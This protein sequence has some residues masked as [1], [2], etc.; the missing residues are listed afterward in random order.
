MKLTPAVRLWMLWTP[1]L[2]SSVGMWPAAAGPCTFQAGLRTRTSPRPK[3]ARR[4][5]MLA[6]SPRF[7]VPVSRLFWPGLL[8]CLAAVTAWAQDSRTGRLQRCNDFNDAATTWKSVAAGSDAPLPL[9]SL[10]PPVLLLDGTEFKTW[11]QPPQHRRTFFVAQQDP[12][13]ADGNP[14]TEQR[15]WK[16][17]GRA[18]ALLEPGDRVVVKAGVYREWVRPARGGAGP[19]RMITY[20]A[21]PGEKIVIRGSERYLGR[22]QSS[23]LAGK[24]RNANAWMADL[25]DS[26][27][28]GYNPLDEGNM[29]AEQAQQM[30]LH[31]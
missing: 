10:D 15:P 18:A 2:F 20:Q 25:P 17:I 9:R 3:Y 14:G 11:E 26:L 31:L 5:S 30:P 23:T 4:R 24:T 19:R 16:T 6:P 21:A 8:V 22:W 28:G 1:L 29:N 13:A 27:F 12:A 7:S